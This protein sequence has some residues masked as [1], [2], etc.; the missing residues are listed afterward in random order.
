MARTRSVVNSTEVVIFSTTKVVLVGDIK[1]RSATCALRR[2]E[3]QIAS[4]IR[5]HSSR[6]A[7]ESV[8]IENLRHILKSYLPACAR[9]PRVGDC[10]LEVPPL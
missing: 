7:V 2:P 3:E 9:L 4:L 5:H 6:V 8:V 1:E 10:S